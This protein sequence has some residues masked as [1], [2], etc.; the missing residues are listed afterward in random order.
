MTMPTATRSQDIPFLP[1]AWAATLK[2]TLHSFG[3]AVILAGCAAAVLALVSYAPTDPSFDTATPISPQNALGLP[4]A[5]FADSALQTVGL[6]IGVFL[7]VIIAWGLR[8]ARGEAV[9][10]LWLR[11]VAAVAATLLIAMGLEVIPAPWWP[12][13][14]GLGGSAGQVLV[15]LVRA[16][17]AP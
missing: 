14:A 11:T 12:V 6:S 3:G 17:S 8:L 5:I 9:G 4:G 13:Q 2:R 16:T 7:A 1:P 10:W 15:D